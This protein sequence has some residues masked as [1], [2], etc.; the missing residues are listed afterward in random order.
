MNARRLPLRLF[1]LV[2]RRAD[3]YCEYCQLHQEFDLLPHHV[4]YVVARKHE[5][6]DTEDNLALAI[7]KQHHGT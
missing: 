5:G 4:D 2:W 3:S 7:P 6:S 1:R